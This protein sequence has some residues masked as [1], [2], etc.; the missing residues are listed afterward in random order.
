MS[1]EE[2]SKLEYSEFPSQTFEAWKEKLVQDSKGKSYDDL[3]ISTKDGIKVPPFFT[4]ETFSKTSTNQNIALPFR[5]GN[6]GFLDLLDA[7]SSS[8]L[9]DQIAES[10]QFGSAGAVVPLS[11]FTSKT[12]LEWSAKD[13]QILFASANKTPGF[14]LHFL[15]GT[16]ED[17]VI[18]SLSHWNSPKGSLAIDPIGTFVQCGEFGGEQEARFQ[19]IVSAFQKAPKEISTLVVSGNLLGE[20]GATQVTEIGAI[21]SWYREYVS[22]L[23]SKGLSIDSIAERTILKISVGTEYFL[24][25]A[26]L[27]AFRGLLNQLLQAFGGT[28]E[29]VTKLK[30]H[31]IT[32]PITYTHFDANTNLLR[33]TTQTISGILGGAEYISI[34]PYTH[35][36]H[37]TTQSRRYARN[38]TH[39]LLNES[40]LEKVEDP[41][42]GSYYVEYLTEQISKESWTSFQGLESSGGFLKN[43]Q[44]GSIQK[45][46]QQSFASAQEAFRSRKQT[47]LGV[48]QFPN[49]N[50]TTDPSQYY[51]PATLSQKEST[52]LPI[53]FPNSF[54]KEFEDLRWKAQAHLQKHPSSVAL[55]SFGNLNMRKARMSFVQNFVGVLGFSSQEILLPLDTNA[56]PEISS[57]A[58][59]SAL[60]KIESTLQE[61]NWEIVFFCSSDDEYLPIL[62][63]LL[64]I[65]HEKK[66]LNSKILGVAGNPST[67]SELQAL[68]I[69]FNIHIKSNLYTTLEKILT[70]LGIS[71]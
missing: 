17:L 71:K 69:D 36:T 10:L 47:L 50:E 53:L 63:H 25:I 32:N 41:S 15:A 22:Y 40:Y 34:V 21:L 31:A 20:S 5:K 52:K 60:A 4:N 56:G 61:K 67:L 13:L 51:F 42:N 7:E 46:I 23:L 14:E 38:T 33:A 54:A 70:I 2:N 29:S 43:F 16:K 39:V 9:Q 18:D 24:E 65:L 62:K 58:V 49:T 66:L 26:K 55:I 11:Q 27:R 57:E 1:K 64:P 35:A 30:I 44:S 37:S 19:K 12:K 59:A 68:G 28:P 48:T 45:T 8:E 6:V 3:T